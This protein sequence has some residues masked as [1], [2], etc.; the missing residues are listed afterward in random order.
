MMRQNENVL[1]YSLLFNN[2]L[3]ELSNLQTLKFTCKYD[4]YI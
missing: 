3:A 2:I 1:N 4:D